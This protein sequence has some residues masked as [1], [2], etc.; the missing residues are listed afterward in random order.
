MVAA[1]PG[2]AARLDAP[3]EWQ[4]VQRGADESAEVELAGA[5]P[6]ETTLVEAKAALAE[7]VRG[8]AADWVVVAKGERT[9]P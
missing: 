9:F 8:R 1:V 7:G 2:F 4:V 3:L 6:A 5:V